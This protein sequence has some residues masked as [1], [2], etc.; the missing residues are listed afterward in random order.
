MR[1]SELLAKLELFGSEVIEI[2]S[3]EFAKM[4]HD[5]DDCIS[6]NA[7]NEHS[8][9]VL[10]VKTDGMTYY[11]YSACFQIGWQGDWD[12]DNF[13]CKVKCLTRAEREEI[14]ALMS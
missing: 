9:F 2:T 14:Y 10:V 3:E 13:Y 8:G 12:A 6:S 11:N 4:M 7:I 1:K 5:N